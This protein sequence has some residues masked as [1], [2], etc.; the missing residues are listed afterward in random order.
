MA[1]KFVDTVY[2]TVQSTDAAGNVAYT[3]TLPDESITMFVVNTVARTSGGT[4]ASYIRAG[5]WS[6]E[7]GGGATLVGGAFTSVHAREDDSGWD[8]QTFAVTGND[9]QIKV[10]GKA[11]TTI[12]WFLEI[13]IVQY[14]P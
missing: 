3:V 4:S 6:R 5:G 14:V 7:A 10:V 1:T 2:A 12:D 11:A 8:Q 9:V 13:H